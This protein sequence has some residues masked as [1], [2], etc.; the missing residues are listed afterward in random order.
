MDIYEKLLKC[1]SVL[2]MLCSIF[3]AAARNFIHPGL[4]HSQDDLKRI[5]RLVKENSYPAMGSYDLLRKVPGASFEYEMKGPFENISRAGKYGYTKAPCESDCNAAYYNALMWNITGDV[6]HADKAMEILRGYA[7][8]LQKIY[9][10]DDPLCA[11]LQGFMLIN[12]AEIMRYTYQDNQY[13]KG[14]SEADT[15]SI[16]GMFRNV[17]LPVLTTFVQAKPY[18]NGN[19]GGSVNKMVMAIG[20]FCNDEPLYNQA[21]DF[22]YNSRD[23]GSLPNYIAETGQLQESGRDQAHCMLGVGVLAELAECAWKQGDNLYAA[24]DNRI[25]K[26]YEYLSKVNLGYTDVPFEVWKDA[27]GKYC[28]WQNMGEAE[29]GKFRAVFEIAYNHYV[30]RRGIAMPYT[31]KVLKRIRPEGIEWTCDNPGFG[32][33]LFYLGKN[34]PV[35][36]EGQISEQL[37]YGWKGWQIAAPDLEPVGN[38]FL[39]VNK[40]ISMQKNRIHYNPSEFPYIKVTFS[41][42]PEEVKDGWLRL[43]YSVQS[44]PEFWT[45][46]EKDAVKVDGNTYWFAVKDARSNNGTLF[47]TRDRHISLLLDFGDIKAV[48]VESIVSESHL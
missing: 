38:E 46:Y 39:L 40:G 37:K 20:I 17:F 1:A 42:K 33:L 36:L 47:G 3:S 2:V 16:E 23:N 32:T 15:K 30:E 18:A 31:E 27:T 24:L 11:G 7:S 19:W 25:M 35:P 5:T 43:S 6:R 29:L 21:V 12:A 28:N 22:F 41:H 48:G 8:T 34:E 4:L 13:V 9:G 26:G 44:A 14:W 45:F 10:P